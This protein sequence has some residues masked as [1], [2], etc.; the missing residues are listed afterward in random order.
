MIISNNLPQKSGTETLVEMKAQ[1]SGPNHST[2][3]VCL[4]AD[5]ISGARE[6]YISVGFTDYLTKLIHPEQLE[7]MLIKLLPKEKC[8]RI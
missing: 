4:T 5:A 1:S 8:T 7:E 6:K 2:P 3:V